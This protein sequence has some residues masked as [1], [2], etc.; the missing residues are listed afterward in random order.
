MRTLRSRAPWLAAA[1][2]VVATA[3][4][5]ND[6]SEP[7]RL[8]DRPDSVDITEFCETAAEAQSLATGPADGEPIDE[9]NARAESAM[10]ILED[11]A[12]DEIR[13]P[14]DT[15]V[16]MVRAAMASDDPSNASFLE[17]PEFVHADH[18]A[19]AYMLEHC[20]AEVVEIGAREHSFEGV[21]LTMPPGLA[22]FTLTNNGHHEHELLVLRVDTDNTVA[23]LV[24]QG[25]GGEQNFT[26]AGK[27]T[28][29]ATDDTD[30][31]F[32]DLEDGRR[33][34]VLCLV[35]EGPADIPHVALGM[36]GEFV[37]TSN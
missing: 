23:E 1:A 25:R 10:Q 5:S 11:G 15:I 24:A 17:D 13:E 16:Q 33:Y 27:A 4:C 7:E 2:L 31:V 21:P 12:P 14:I 18:A 28:T 34:G 6:S 9:F 37:V 32:V 29:P 36:H 3:A 30:T 35:T 26:F 8:P 22:A 20:N 19:D